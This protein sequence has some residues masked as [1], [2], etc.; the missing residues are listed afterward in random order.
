MTTETKPAQ[1]GRGH[2]EPDIHDAVAK[3]VAAWWWGAADEDIAGHVAVAKMIARDPIN[4][5]IYLARI[6]EDG[7]QYRKLKEWA[8]K[9]AVEFAGAKGSAQRRRSL[10]E[11]YRT[12]WGHQAARDGMARALWPWLEHEMPGRNAQADRLKAGHQAYQRVRD[13]VQSR[14]L[15]GFI[16]FMFDLGCLAEGRWT[17][18]MIAR[19]EA[20]TGAEFRLAL[21]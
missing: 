17:R 11:S 6:A 2:E 15:D 7:S 5:A 20:A 9:A 4:E 19:W 16:A 13:E 3:R 14:T 12:D 10:V 18:D 21:I 1:I 8:Y